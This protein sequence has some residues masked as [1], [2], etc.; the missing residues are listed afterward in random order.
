M[1]KPWGSYEH[2]SKHHHLVAD[3]GWL[4]V[5]CYRNWLGFFCFGGDIK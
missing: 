3:Y 2:L 1:R 5:Y 4:Y